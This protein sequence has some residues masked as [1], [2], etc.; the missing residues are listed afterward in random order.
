MERIKILFDV[1]TKV[2]TCVTFGMI[3]Y[4][5][6]FFPGISFG[7]E[8]LWQMLLVSFLTSAGTLLYKDDI[9]QKNMKV[10]CVV[11]YLLVNVIVV[12]CGLWFG[13]FSLG[14][15]PQMT[16]ILIVIALVFLAVSAVSWKKARQMAD[17]M[18]SRLSEYQEK[19]S[20]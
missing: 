12:G 6:L 11:H 18:N 4:C 3:V 13:W 16:G 1:F 8:M 2:V 10:M 20:Q 5:M 15:V 17:L 19:Q 7:I 14:N 9:R